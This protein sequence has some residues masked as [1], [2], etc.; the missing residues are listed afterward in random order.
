MNVAVKPARPSQQGRAAFPAL[1]ELKLRLRNGVVEF[2]S[3]GRAIS[4]EEKPQDP[5]SHYAVPGLL[6]PVAA[7][8]RALADGVNA[9][10]SHRGQMIE[11]ELPFLAEANGGR[12]FEIVPVVVGALDREG[13]RALASELAALDAP[14]TVFVFSVDL[15]HFYPYDVAV[16]KDRPCLD[17]IVRMDAE[18]VARCDTDATQVLLSMVAPWSYTCGWELATKSHYRRFRRQYLA[19]P[20]HS[21][22]EGGNHLTVRFLFPSLT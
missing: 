14:G 10:A 17:A 8:G 4:I 3:Q 5:K 19:E 11:I 13:A 22:N 21:V 7:E 16:S 20:S 6:V 15:S 1:S 9:P 12:P 2:D 18:A